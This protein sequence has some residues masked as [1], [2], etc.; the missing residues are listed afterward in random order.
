MVVRN[1][2]NEKKILNKAYE[3]LY[4]ADTILDSCISEGRTP[5]DYELSRIANLNYEVMNML[6]D[7]YFTKLKLSE[8]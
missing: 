3:M 5:T 2:H 7:L 1:K 4:K 8:N 6:H